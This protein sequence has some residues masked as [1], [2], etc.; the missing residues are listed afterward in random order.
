MTDNI[1]KI[2]KVVLWVLVA[3]SMFFALMLF[4]NTSEED[5][6]WINNSLQFTKIILYII[7]GLTIFF[8]LMIY[9]LTLIEKPRKALIKLIPFILLA[10]IFIIGLSLASDI[11]LHMPNY[12]GDANTPLQNKWTGVGLIMMYIILGLAVLSIIVTSIARIFK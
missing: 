5:V 3:L 4:T 1:A 8:S 11:P 2:T 10:I 7:I 12:D 9:V 6:T